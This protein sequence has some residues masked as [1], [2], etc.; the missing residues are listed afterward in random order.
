[1]MKTHKALQ[2]LRLIAV[3]FCAVVLPALTPGCS[4]ERDAAGD[5]CNPSVCGAPLVCSFGHCILPL[6]D[7]GVDSGPVADAGGED[8]A[9]CGTEGIC[10]NDSHCVSDVCTAWGPGAFDPSCHRGGVAGTIRPALQC[11]WSGPPAGDG[12]PNSLN[13]DHTPIVANLRIETDPDAA[14]RPSIIFIT[15]DGY[16]ESFAGDVRQCESRGVLRVMDGATCETQASHTNEDERVAGQVAPAVADLDGDG[17]AEIVA[18]AA[19]GGLLAFAW[20]PTARALVKVW[21]STTST[22]SVDVHRAPCRWGGIQLADLDNDGMPEIVF[23]DAVWS[24]SGVF[25]STIPEYMQAGFVHGGAPM[26]LADVDLDG[27]VELV[28]G[29]GTWRWNASSNQFEIES[30]FEEGPHTGLAGFA[31]V[32]D[33]G[34]FPGFAGD[35]PGR[36]EVVSVMGGE[37]RLQTIAGALIVALGSYG[38][39]WNG[40]P[41]TIADYDGDTKPEV[42]AAFGTAYAVFD[43]ID[44]RML[45]DMPSQDFS[46]R[47]TGSSV[48]DFNADGR[49]EVVYADECFT[50]IYDG[51]TGEVLFS[52]PR[53]SATWLENPVVAD[54]DGDNAAEIVVASGSVETP[55]AP[56]PDYCGPVDPIF[57]GLTCD[58]ET[59]C[60]GGACS[61]G[62]CR[63]A[64]NADCGGSYSCEPP[65]SGTPG[66]GNVCRARFDHCEAGVLVY[67]DARDRW[68]PSRDTW[69]QHAY[70]V[71]NIENDLSVESTSTMMCNWQDSTLNNFRQNVQDPFAIL[72]AADLTVRNLVANCEDSNTR[73]SADVCNRGEALSDAN[74]QII[75]RQVGGDELCR[76]QTAEPIPGGTCRMFDCVAAVRAEGAFEGVADPDGTIDE[77]NEGNNLGEGLAHCLF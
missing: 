45:W 59:D 51:P 38:S 69:N 75:F 54:V 15:D 62:Y 70:F 72:S 74:V 19:D 35:A 61:A 14:P 41:P 48:F 17:R 30:Y 49:A 33:F 1:M 42:G 18:A 24:H 23:D 25:L 52:Q 55:C 32:A 6:T 34:D 28:S 3:L 13:V 9:T 56:S 40:G 58:A 22:G 4:C 60:P 66:S 63:C 76:L 77:C 65:I 21:H 67:R 43:P 37:V 12:A 57:K 53:F 36:P 39:E 71:T 46:S 2:N 73:I 44:G 20:D 10:Q 27:E 11:S 29:E 8:A 5:P 64:S 50:R 26:V 16:S 68:A 31:A 47:V 7:S